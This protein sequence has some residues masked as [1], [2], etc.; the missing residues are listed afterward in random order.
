MS[1]IASLAGATLRWRQPS[2]FKEHHELVAD[3]G[4]IVARLDGSGKFLSEKFTAE[5]FGGNWEFVFADFWRLTV[6]IR[7]T[8]KDLPFATLVGKAFSMEKTLELPRGERWKVGYRMWKG[9]YEVTD[10]RGM[11]VVTARSKL[12]FKWNAEV[13]VPSYTA[14]LERCPWAVMLIYMLQVRQR[15]RASHG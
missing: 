14:P 4:S 12:S 13:T 1:T 9:L 10:G 15:R 7:E 5:G 11:P 6:G 8:G 3:D 2:I